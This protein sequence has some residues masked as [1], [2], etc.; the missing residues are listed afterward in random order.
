[1]VFAGTD[2]IRIWDLVTMEEIPVSRDFH[3]RERTHISSLRW[4]NHSSDL[5]PETLC[6]GNVLG[7]FVFLQRSKDKVSTSLFRS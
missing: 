4:I 2:G 7:F 3:A 1:M 5:G 6:Y